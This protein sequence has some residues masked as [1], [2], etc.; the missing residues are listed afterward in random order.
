VAKYL[1]R[2]AGPSSVK[3]PLNLRGSWRIDLPGDFDLDK[4]L[5]EIRGEWK[6]ELDFDL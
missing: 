3:K 1:Q 6:K 4:A 2:P 5:A